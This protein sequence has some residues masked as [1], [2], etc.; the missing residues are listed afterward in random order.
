MDQADSK[1]ADSSST[2]TE[3]SCHCHP[4][5]AVHERITACAHAVE[6]IP[7][8]IGEANVSQR[9]V[10]PSAC[11]ACNMTGRGSGGG[12]GGG[13]G[14][15]QGLSPAEPQGHC[16]Q[17]RECYGCSSYVEGA[18]WCKSPRSR[19]D[20]SCTH[21]RT[22][23]P[24]YMNDAGPS[25]IHKPVAADTTLPKP[26]IGVPYP[27][28]NHRVNEALHKDDENKVTQELAAFRNSS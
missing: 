21:Q 7:A 5:G 24:S 20:D 18:I 26:S 25:K 8:I 13:G 4:G 17:S 2:G 3:S 11:G 10:L 19:S 16:A 27:V 6:A 1:A 9:A 28:G 23:T 15:V 12:G 14:G 22:G